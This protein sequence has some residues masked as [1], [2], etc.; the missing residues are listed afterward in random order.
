M[1]STKSTLLIPVELQVRELEPKLL[2]ACC[3]A[4]RGFRAII[5]PRREMHFYLYHFPKSIYLSKS[6]TNAS[7]NVFRNLQR[8]GSQIAVWDEEALVALPPKLYY[9]HRLSPVSMRYVSHL[10]AWGEANAELWRGYPNLPDGIPIH[11]TGNPRADLLRRDLRVYYEND[12]SALRQTYGDFILVNTNF[13]LINAYHSDMN[14]LMPSQNPGEGMILSRRSESLGLDRDYAEGFT[15]YKHAILQSFL[16]LVPA[17]ARSFPE[18]TIV[19]R[20]H[21]AENQDIYHRLAQ[22]SA[23]VQVINK[24]N[25]V[26]WL[27]AAK[28]LIHN[29]CTTGIEAY[30]LDTPALAYRRSV[31]EQYDRDFHQ[32]P[33]QLSHE[34][35]SF[36]ELYRT[37]QKI[38]HGQLGMA[39]GEKRRALMHRHLSA[40]SGPLACARIMDV[41]EQ[42][43]EDMSRTADPTM[44]DKLKI[45]VWSHRR[46][47]KKRLR[48]YRPNMSH[49]RPDFLKHRYPT[50]SLEDMRLRVSRFQQLLGYDQ[51]LKVEQFAN[52]FFQISKLEI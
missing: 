18:Y 32:L 4:M 5:G 39:N 24:G 38:L 26:P 43:M 46:R 10:F 35:F 20:P 23:R 34:C 52:Q 12:V 51:E 37:L 1:K 41:L 28:A 25:V 42:I 44:L 29:G 16:E 9:R 3:A 50:I 8:L 7:K 22:T 31:H 36:E 17:L 21:P 40:Q 47:L 48:G 13:N 45:R 6:T 14:L 33:N 27:L 11:I 19:V 30:A 49:N 2:L 15:A